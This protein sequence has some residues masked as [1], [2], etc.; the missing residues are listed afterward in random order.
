MVMKKTLA[1]AVGL[2]VM[3][4]VALIMVPVNLSAQMDR[5]DAA[6]TSGSIFEFGILPLGALALVAIVT[7]I[8][9]GT[10]AVASQERA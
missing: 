6:G 7:G 4:I 9:V 1:L 3:G 8:A 2:I 10:R 5:V